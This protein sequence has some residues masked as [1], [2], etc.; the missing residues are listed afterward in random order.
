MVVYSFNHST[1]GGR[2]RRISVSSRPAWSKKIKF[3]DRQQR[4][5]VSK[6]KQKQIK[7]NK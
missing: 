4:N 1:P 7:T 2:G 3:W 5:P 6:T